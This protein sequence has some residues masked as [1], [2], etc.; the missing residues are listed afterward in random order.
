MDNA[1]FHHSKHFERMCSDFRV[2]PLYLPPYSPDLN[3]I[4]EMFADLKAFVK[5]NWKAHEEDPHHY[6]L[7]PRLHSIGN[8]V[9][10][11]IQKVVLTSNRRLSTCH[12]PQVHVQ[13]TNTLRL[14]SVDNILYSVLFTIHKLASKIH[15]CMSGWN[16][17]RLWIDALH[18]GQGRSQN[19]SSSF[20]VSIF[21]APHPFV[22]LYA[23]VLGQ[24]GHIFMNIICIVALWLVSTSLICSFLHRA[25]NQEHRNRHRSRPPSRLRRCLWRRPPFL[26][27]GIPSLCRRSTPQRCNWKG[28]GDCADCWAITLLDTEQSRK[29]KWIN[30]FRANDRVF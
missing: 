11:K 24:G 26:R 21:G 3:P 27:L 30:W 25:Y 13:P 19:I 8:I 6:A 16:F 9:K 22:T 15:D 29:G 17:P 5:R 4:E 23:V 14:D 7:W 18:T 2:K 12:P 1:S 28:C 10:H 20:I